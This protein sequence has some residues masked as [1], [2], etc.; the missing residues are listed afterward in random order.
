VDH[1][2]FAR[3]QK[4]TAKAMNGRMM[5]A[6]IASVEGSDKKRSI[7]DRIVE[8]V[9]GKAGV[10]RRKNVDDDA[11]GDA[12]KRRARAYAKYLMEK[13]GQLKARDYLVELDMTPKQKCKD[14]DETLPEHMDGNG[15]NR[16][17]AV[18]TCESVLLAVKK[19]RAIYRHSTLY[20]ALKK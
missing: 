9:S 19:A 14:L 16:T 10:P 13:H 11:E 4:A 1:L 5:A 20:P 12:H 15:W 2:P 18:H 8:L 17:E 6:T 7:P 3:Q